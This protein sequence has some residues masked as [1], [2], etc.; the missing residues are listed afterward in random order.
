[1]AAT[2]SGVDLFSGNAAW[3][4]SIVSLPGRGLNV[5]LKLAYNSL[6]YLNDGGKLRFDPLGSGPAPGF[7]LGLPQ[8]AVVEGGSSLV[9]VDS[10]GRA[11]ELRSSE[12]PTEYLAVDSSGRK[13]HLTGNKAVMRDRT[14]TV[15]EFSRYGYRYVCTRVVDLSGNV[16]TAQYASD[17]RLTSIEDT[18]GRIIRFR[19]DHSQHLIEVDR[20]IAGASSPVATLT[21]QKEHSLPVSTDGTS[22]GALA[23]VTFDA[24]SSISLQDG[25]SF[26]FDYDDSGLISKISRLAP[27]GSLLRYTAYSYASW[28]TGNYGA[29]PRTSRLESG[30][31]N[32]AG[33]ITNSATISP[34]SSDGMASIVWQDGRSTFA[35]FALTGDYEGKVLSQTDR[36]P[37]AYRRSSVT[38]EKTTWQKVVVAGVSQILRSSLES[39]GM[40][41]GE[42]MLH[43]LVHFDSFGRQTELTMDNADGGQV[44]TS[45]TVYDDRAQFKELNILTAVR[46]VRTSQP[47]HSVRSTTF[48]YDEEQPV[49]Q[50]GVLHHLDRSPY[51]P[52]GLLAKPTHITHEC[53]GCKSTLPTHSIA[54]ITYNSTG[55]RASFQ[56]TGGH[57]VSWDFSDSFAE[58]LNLHTQAYATSVTI[59]GKTQR[60]S[61]SLQNGRI[62]TID[63][64]NGEKVRYQYD[65]VGR[66]SAQA[67]LSKGITTTRTYGADGRSVLVTSKNAKGTTSH[68]IIRDGAG[69]LAAVASQVSPGSNEFRAAFFTY[70][71]FGHRSRRMSAAYVDATWHTTRPTY[72]L[73]T[74]RR[75]TH[76][77]TASPSTQSSLSPVWSLLPTSPAMEVFAQA[78]CY[79]STYV[80]DQGEEYRIDD[81]SYFDS[82]DSGIDDSP[83]DYA[84]W[85]SI[86]D[87][88][89]NDG[90]GTFDE[91]A[92]QTEWSDETDQTTTASG[93]GI[94]AG[95]F[96]E[97]VTNELNQS[98]YADLL[99]SYNGPEWE[100]S[101]NS[102]Y[103]FYLSSSDASQLFSDLQSDSNFKCGAL[104]GFHTTL[105]DG[106]GGMFDCRSITGTYG[107]GSMQIVGSTATGEVH[108]DVDR[109]NP[110][111][112]VVNFLGHAFIEVLPHL[113]R[114]K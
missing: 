48:S 15:L 65:S 17:G 8:L 49:Q 31:V 113:F 102:G 114:F 74:N 45:R 99:Q 103:H 79:D 33:T 93:N 92:M 84:A 23:P 96:Q 3:Q 16:V 76:Q 52:Y 54:S 7:S 32:P 63:K 112:D 6:V 14:G 61:Y 86:A 83:S 64:A 9:F 100:S 53:A 44:T 111:Q 36:S 46:E 104:Y 38:T 80:V 28:N 57:A 81:D 101:E 40:A 39:N 41:N 69:R 11:T 2:A 62:R 85:T 78:T 87:E 108:V 51:N 98:N 89:E 4:Q 109:F 5:N 30:S 26:K 82:T 19:Y 60:Q 24:L 105:A 97:I 110:Y 66:V 43:V 20:I 107:Y 73:E 75:N 18:L 68:A 10:E 94:A 47:D 90:E 37:K 12:D 91:G 25:G 72:R 34:P 71:K 50:S 56:S 29:V 58:A 42:R 59:D 35:R 1:M 77:E 106:Q 22:Q 27:D 70:N 95:S 88:Y 21:Y 67:N 13:L 55:T